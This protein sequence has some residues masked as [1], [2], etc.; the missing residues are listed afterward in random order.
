MNFENSYYYTKDNSIVYLFKPSKNSNLE[1]VVDEGK[2]EK[3]EYLGRID[4]D[5][6]IYF[7]NNEGDCITND[8]KSITEKVRDYKLMET[9]SK[10]I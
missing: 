4:K 6:N 3:V 5:I 7:Y 8:K 9:L 2:L 10:N 1:I